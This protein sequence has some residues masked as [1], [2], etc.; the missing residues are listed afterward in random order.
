MLKKGEK[1]IPP[2]FMKNRNDKYFLIENSTICLKL[3]LISI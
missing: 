3:C 2:E 1:Y